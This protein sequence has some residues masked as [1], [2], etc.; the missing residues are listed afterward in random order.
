MLDEIILIAIRKDVGDYNAS[1][2]TEVLRL[3]K[4]RC[5]V[6]PP[7][8]IRTWLGYCN[9]IAVGFPAANSHVYLIHI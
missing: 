6:A 2:G 4:V 5:V 3:I 9:R 7:M 1:L 8:S